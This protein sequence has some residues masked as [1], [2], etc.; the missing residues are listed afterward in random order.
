MRYISPKYFLGLVKRLRAL[1]FNLLPV[2][3]PVNLVTS[4][5]SRFIT[6]QVVKA[7]VAAAGDLVETV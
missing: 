1:T 2:E 4:P 3:V 7:Y 6:P 5:T